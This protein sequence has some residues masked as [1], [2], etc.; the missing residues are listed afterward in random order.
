MGAGAAPGPGALSSCPARH[1]VWNSTP[2]RGRTAG[3]H[4]LRPA[5]LLWLASLTLLPCPSA[6][7]PCQSRA[8]GPVPA[9]QLGLGRGVW[10]HHASGVPGWVSRALQACIVASCTL[11][12]VLV[13][14]RSY[15]QHV[16]STALVELRSL[17]P[18]LPTTSPPHPKP[19]G[20]LKH[21]VV[22]GPAARQPRLLRAVW[23]QLA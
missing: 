19:A 1:R 8:G 21:Q 4:P 18:L 10:P 15:C 3:L 13:V 6:A 7:V 23:A 5:K 14:P 16:W 20:G 12:F 11:H 17:L 2:G 9:G 22:A